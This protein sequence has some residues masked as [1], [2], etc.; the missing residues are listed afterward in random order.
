MSIGTTCSAEVAQRHVPTRGHRICQDAAS[1]SQ[2]A[3]VETAAVRAEGVHAERHTVLFVCDRL[4]VGLVSVR[5]RVRQPE[6]DAD[7]DEIGY[8]RLSTQSEHAN[9]L[10]LLRPQRKI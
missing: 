2:F 3:L 10:R 1:R 8:Q 9:K 4:E 5:Q 7:H 6:A